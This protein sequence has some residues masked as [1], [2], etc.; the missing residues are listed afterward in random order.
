[1]TPGSTEGTLLEDIAH[2]SQEGRNSARTGHTS[3]HAHLLH[4][5]LPG[6][7]M[8]LGSAH[9]EARG[10]GVAEGAGKLT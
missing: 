7:R 6:H 8:N 4:V 2:G 9:L 10:W 1:M 5:G 3:P